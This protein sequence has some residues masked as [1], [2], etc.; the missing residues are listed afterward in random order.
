M[1]RP[2]IVAMVATRAREY[3]LLNRALPSIQS[4]SRLA[5][6]II[7]IDD[8]KS[9]DLGSRMTAAVPT[10]Q[11]L[12]NRRTP[13]L[14]GA[15][16][17][18]L[19]HLARITP[20]PAAIVV[21]IL[22][23]DDAWLPEHLVAIEARILEGAEVVAVPFLRVEAGR[24]TSRVAP[25]TSV[26]PDLFMERNPGIQ[27]A[28]FAARL[29]ILLEAG[30]FNE[31][32]RSCTDRDLWIRLC[33]RAELRYATTSVPSVLHHACAERLRLSSPGSEA[34]RAGLDMFD[35]I[36]GPMMQPATREKH[37]DRA[38]RLFDWRPTCASVEDGATCAPTPPQEAETP[39]LLVGIIADDRRVLALSR[40]LDDLADRVE[41]EGL[42]PPD[43]LLLENRPETTSGQA[44][45][46]MVSQK[47]GRLHIHLIGR[48]SL[49]RLAE[50][51]EWQPEGSDLRGRLAIADARTALQSCLYHMALKRPGCAI[52]ILDDDMR[53]DPIIAQASGPVRQTLRLGQ[54]LRRMRA[55]GADIVIGSYTGAPPLPAVASVRGQLVDLLANVRR[56]SSYPEEAPVPPAAPHN[57]ALRARRRDYYHDLSRIETD[58]LETPFALE[59]MHPDERCGAALVRLGAMIPRILAG[60]APLRTLVAE[61]EEI[62]A[63]APA[64]ALHRGGNTFIFDPE[65]LAD[66]PNLSPTVEGRPARRSDMIWALM[67]KR[68]FGRHVISVP[69][70]VRH[71]RSNTPAPDALDH[72]GIADDLR[73]FAIFSAL[74]DAGENSV[75]VEFLCDKYE[76]ERLAALRLS[77]HRVRGLAR[78]LLAWSQNAAPR[79]APRIALAAQARQLL[80]MFSPDEFT[81]IETSV[82]ALGPVQ[83]RDFLAGLPAYIAAHAE[84]IHR[85]IVIPSLLMESR[86]KAARTAIAPH[87]QA[88]ATLRVLG[89]GS[90]GVVFTDGRTIWKLFDCWSAEQAARATPVLQRLTDS[91]ISGTSLIKPLAL[92]RTRSG[93]LLSLP[94]EVS[95]PWTGGHGPGLV[96][97]VADLHRAG[98]VCR[99]L[100]PKNLRVANGAVRLI[101]YGADMLPIDDP[102]AISLEFQ[103]M[104]RRAWLCW[105]WWWR[106]DLDQLLRLSLHEADLPELEGHENLIRAVRERLGL[107]L[108]P[109]PTITRALAL[110]PTRV[111]DYGAGKGK[112]AATLARAGAELIAWDPDPDVAARLDK[113]KPL[114]VRR[115]I[116]AAEAVATGPFDLVICR[117][118]AC[119]IGDAALDTVL[120]DLRAAL[121]PEGRVL[122]TVCHPAYAHRVRVADAEPLT[123]PCNCG[124]APWTKR[125]HATGRV[126]HEVHRSERLLRRR[127]MRAGLRVL[128]R[129]ERVRT[130]FDRFETVADILTLELTAAPKPSVSLLIKACA[131]DA[132]ALDHQVRDILAAL[133]EPAVFR[134][135]VL[136]LDTRT[137]NFPRAHAAGDLTALRAAAKRLLA[138]GEIDRI[139]EAPSSAEALRALN[140]R[141]FGL[142]LP[143]SHSAGGAATGALLAG[144]DA[145]CAPRVLH[146]DLDMMIARTDSI[147]DPIRDP[148]RE[149]LEA[150]D[151][152]RVLPR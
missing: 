125:V 63:F 150:L 23:D 152:D 62:E 38:A 143:A 127:L 108:P 88:E 55:T 97:L 129:H 16:N 66:L 77:F 26:S 32:L 149:L 60:E 17:T 44:L 68:R 136:A 86:V 137:D 50:A 47:R 89:Q 92:T 69:F 40:L 49:E 111:L 54:A 133:E 4:Q 147:R 73:G 126:L 83:V 138:E 122:F 36:H 1:P 8:G 144:F 35:R 58:R 101:D 20:D 72:S 123:P 134:E 46:A 116:S 84:R 53:L 2:A 24:D 11:Y 67:Q 107:N 56:L 45:A 105:R 70:P 74:Q 15:L 104:C 33:R 65:A 117:R 100:H 91:P 31:A 130:E 103:R 82:R 93:W 76:E 145:C 57:A 139:V 61:P 37:L 113:L 141:W 28:T 30:G 128:G 6:A 21:A 94:F 75:H 119:L 95:R 115:T 42:E 59:P 99:N 14:S 151:A 148:I 52:W 121:A 3:F 140:H 34:K 85:A 80:Q 10:A 102:E 27:G 25:P 96:E 39:P 7:V 9:P 112:Q 71:D 51:G 110:R 142:D 132:E 18:G 29:D 43:V 109:D 78:E 12:R 120:H 22:D 90:E 131:M 41:A 79:H 87:I 146:A 118:V 106:E 114:G 98:L 64:D 19:D 48:T 81:R 124:T 13:G 135:T 5:D